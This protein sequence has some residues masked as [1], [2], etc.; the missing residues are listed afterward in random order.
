MPSSPLNA[1][2]MTEEKALL[3]PKRLDRVQASGLI[4]RIE[5]K[6]EPYDEGEE[7]R[8]RNNVA[9]N[10]RWPAGN[11]SCELRAHDP[12]YDTKGSTDHTQG[13]GFY[14]KLHYDMP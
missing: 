4:S 2:G 11:H 7:K 5:T 6:E 1:A 13:H 14:Q 3:V 8:D 12:Q 10:N 9:G